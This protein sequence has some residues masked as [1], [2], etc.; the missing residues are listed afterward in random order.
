MSLSKDPPEP[1]GEPP[2]TPEM[3]GK[4]K[5]VR[6]LT[7]AAAGL[8]LVIALLYA[9][10]AMFSAEDLEREYNTEPGTYYLI[11]AIFLLHAG[12][13]ARLGLL[14]ARGGA[15][16]RTG[17]LAWA[18]AGIFLGLVSSPIG[19][20]N[21]VLTVLVIIFLCQ[22]PARDWFARARS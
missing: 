16:L 8:N 5:N 17:L 4:V 10:T 20:V 13:G 1:Y 12:V 11:G 9:S 21:C 6:T 18:V 14:L 22:A 3:P 7:F 2:G 15:N 19:L